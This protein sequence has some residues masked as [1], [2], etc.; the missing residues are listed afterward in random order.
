MKNFVSLKTRKSH[1]VI[2]K[3][4]MNVI[5]QTAER[6]SSFP[7]KNSSDAKPSKKAYLAKHLTYFT[8]MTPGLKIYWT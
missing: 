6:T 3:I 7:L 5:L 1:G 8:Y 4:D 2:V